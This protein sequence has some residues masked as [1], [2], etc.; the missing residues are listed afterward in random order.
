MA[1]TRGQILAQNDIEVK[2][3][4]VPVWDGDVWIRQLTRGEQDEYLKRRFAEMKRTG[5]EEFSSLN[6][7]GHDAWLCVC[8]VSDK[9]GKREFENTPEEIAELNEKNGEAV[10]FLAREI[11][12]FSGMREEVED[13][14][15]VKN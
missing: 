3:V 8:A 7:Y 11:V 2:K 15:E 14:E 5:E 13:I 9:D 6:L 4:H 12:I 10:G 1:L